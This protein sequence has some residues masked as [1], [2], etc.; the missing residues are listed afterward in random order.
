MKNKKN[1]FSIFWIAI[2]NIFEISD[3]SKKDLRFYENSLSTPN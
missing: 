3:F 1:F 2:K